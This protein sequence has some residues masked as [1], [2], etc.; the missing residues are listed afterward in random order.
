MSFW[1]AFCPLKSYETNHSQ[2]KAVVLTSLTVLLSSLPACLSI[3]PFLS[4]LHSVP[5]LPVTHPTPPPSLS[6]LCTNEAADIPD[7]L[8]QLLQDLFFVTN[9]QQLESR[10]MH[11]N[12]VCVIWWQVR[13]NQ[14]PS[15]WMRGVQGRGIWGA[16]W[17]TGS[18]QGR[19]HS[20]LLVCINGLYSSNGRH[21]TQ[22]SASK[23]I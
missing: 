15:G 11:V 16:G 2:Q 19:R 4:L 3:F 22:P 10:G 7:L 5:L 13:F 6:S 9:L 17:W 21:K 1:R 18:G 20:A 8:S 14:A 12:F 23:D